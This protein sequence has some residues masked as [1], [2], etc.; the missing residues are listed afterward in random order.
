MAGPCLVTECTRTCGSVPFEISAVVSATK[1]C[2]LV[3][4]FIEFRLVLFSSLRS[5]FI[6][7]LAA[8]LGPG[9]NATIKKKLLN[10]N[11]VAKTIVTDYNGPFLKPE[12][13]VYEIDFG[14]PKSKQTLVAGLLD[15]LTKL[16]T[17][18]SLVKKNVDTRMGFVIGK[19]L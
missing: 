8:E 2:S 16:F 14:Y 19:L 15:T 11:A 1:S 7:S 12:G 5:T 3:R 10:I 4:M 17:D 18:Q 13:S 9:L 6:G